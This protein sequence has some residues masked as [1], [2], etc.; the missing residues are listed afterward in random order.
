IQRSTYG[1]DPELFE[2]LGVFCSIETN[3]LSPVHA[4]NLA[5]GQLGNFR[6][7]DRCKLSPYLRALG[8]SVEIFHVNWI[9]VELSVPLDVG[10]KLM[11]A[12]TSHRNIL[13]QELEYMLHRRQEVTG[14][15]CVGMTTVVLGAD[16]RAQVG[17]CFDQRDIPPAHESQLMCRG[18]AG[19]SPSNDQS[20]LHH[21]LQFLAKLHRGASESTPPFAPCTSRS[22]KSSS[23]P[24]SAARAAPS[25]RISRTRK[26]CAAIRLN[27][28]LIDLGR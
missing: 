8:H 20:C 18:A 27:R 21:L 3:E 12:A 15:E 26:I 19:K 28:W 14:A 24:R 10:D 16:A 25:R 23:A 13:V 7:I 17:Q 4:G 2:I 6:E 9:I 22:I 1:I 11:L 5:A